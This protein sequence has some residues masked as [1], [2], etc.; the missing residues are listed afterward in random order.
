MAQQSPT[1]GRDNHEQRLPRTLAE[2]RLQEGRENRKRRLLAL[3]RHIRVRGYNFDRE[4]SAKA[5]E[6]PPTRL[7]MRGNYERRM[8]MSSLVE[9]EAGSSSLS[10]PRP[11][12]LVCR[13]DLVTNLLLT[14]FGVQNSGRYFMTSLTWT[15]TAIWKRR[16]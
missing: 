13:L 4:P 7:K 6:K 9:W 8:N 11:R 16:N 15:G 12:K 1:T 2:F 5:L 14:L 3:W 10:M